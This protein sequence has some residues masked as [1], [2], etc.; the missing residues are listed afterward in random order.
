L[1]EGLDEAALAT[2]RRGERTGRP[3]GGADF[4]ARLEAETGRTLLPRKCGPKL[5]RELDSRDEDSLV[6]SRPAGFHRRPL[7]EPCVRL[8]RHTAPVR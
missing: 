7:S 1:A 2:I 8:S 5:S 3:L 4:V 6:V